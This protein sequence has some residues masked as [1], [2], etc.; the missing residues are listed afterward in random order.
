MGYKDDAA[1]FQGDTKEC[2]HM[3]EGRRWL[4]LDAITPD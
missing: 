4:I 2:I 3:R 1:G